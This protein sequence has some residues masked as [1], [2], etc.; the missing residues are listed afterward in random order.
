MANGEADIFS[1][2]LGQPGAEAQAQALAEAL[3][4]RQQQAAFQRGSG[5]LALLSGDSVLGRFGQS[6]LAG[7]GQQEEAAAREQGLIAQAG[8]QQAGRQLQ[9]LLAERQQA[10][11]AKEGALNRAQELAIAGGKLEAA[12]GQ[13]AA[14]QA[15]A[16][17]K[18]ATDLR[19]EFAG[20]PVFKSF[21]EIGT[22]YDKLKL[23]A[24]K[25]GAVSDLAVIF[26]YMKLLDPGVSVMEGDVANATNA[27]GVP[28]HVRNIWN[29]MIRGG[30]LAPE[31]RANMVSQ[32]GDLYGVHLNRFNTLKDYYKGLATKSGV[33]A[34]D[35]VMEAQSP[36]VGAP[37]GASFDL[38]QPVA[39]PA[40]ADAAPAAAGAV[41]EQS[42]DWVDLGGGVRAIRQPNG[43]YVVPE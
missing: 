24:A 15:A 12:K 1:L 43:K 28:D 39:P 21:N 13:A 41:P 8:G 7:A 25:P 6:Q 35:V 40:A 10:F 38:G 32:G 29:Q 14:E 22:S 23:A 3:R 33:S 20:T 34:A 31:Q 11:Q 18:T 36:A 30:K 26:N 9:Q 5:N 16:L 19:K 27:R 37:G 17:Q 42:P 4:K 2:F